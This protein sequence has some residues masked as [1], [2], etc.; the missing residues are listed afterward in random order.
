VEVGHRSGKDWG[1][2]LGL[3]IGHREGLGRGNWL[4]GAD[5]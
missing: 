3:S 4:V 5:F 2:A 1:A